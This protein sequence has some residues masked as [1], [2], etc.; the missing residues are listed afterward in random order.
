MKKF[1]DDS[2]SCVEGGRDEGKSRLRN[3]LVVINDKSEG[4]ESK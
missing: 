4:E 2:E 1:V 3:F